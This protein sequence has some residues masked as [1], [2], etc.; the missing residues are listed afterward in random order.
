APMM[1]TTS[2][3]LRG[4]RCPCPG[5]VE[6]R[7]VTGDPI[8]SDRSGRANESACRREWVSK[9][10]HVIEMLNRL[11]DEIEA[12]RGEKFD[13]DRLAAEMGTTGYH[14]RRMFSS[15]A[16][17]PVSDYIRRRRMTVAAA[18]VVG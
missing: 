16:A 3:D 10:V 17:M 12:H 11:V 5:A 4:T 9:G 13:I 15:L 2:D 14:L 1:N 7:V 18:D 8:E 6:R